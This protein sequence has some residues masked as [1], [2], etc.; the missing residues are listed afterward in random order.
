MASVTIPSLLD[1]SRVSPLLG[2]LKSVV[3]MIVYFDNKITYILTSSVVSL[4]ESLSN[5][6]W[7]SISLS[8]QLH[9]PFLYVLSCSPLPFH[10]TYSYSLLPFFFIYKPSIYLPFITFLLLYVLFFFIFPF[11]LFTLLSYLSFSFLCSNV[12]LTLLVQPLACCVCILYS[13]IIHISVYF[14]IPRH[15]VGRG[16]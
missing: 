10:K 12:Y 1:Y 2:L 6:P 3:S 15:G 16:L 13:L 11:L 8:F 4:F 5:K 7:P 14:L 9:F